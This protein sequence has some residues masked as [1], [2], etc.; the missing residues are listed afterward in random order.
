MEK[1]INILH[2]H[3]DYILVNEKKEVSMNE[4]FYLCLKNV[5]IIF[6]TIFTAECV[7]DF[8]KLLEK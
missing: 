7:M 3:G 4:R 6:L 5:A 2:I 8:K 1:K